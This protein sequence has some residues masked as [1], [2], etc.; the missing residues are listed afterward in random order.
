MCTFLEK[1]EKKPTINGFCIL[2]SLYEGKLD[3]IY[4]YVTLPTNSAYHDF[5]VVTTG[6]LDGIKYLAR[7]RTGYSPDFCFRIK[8]GDDGKL[9]TNEVELTEMRIKYAKNLGGIAAV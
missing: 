2:Q 1:K 9:V 6:G 8:L 3:A 5:E 7:H 4:L